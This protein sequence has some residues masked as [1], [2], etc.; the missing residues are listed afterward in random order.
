[1]SQQSIDDAPFKGSGLEDDLT[2]LK[3][4]VLDASKIALKHFGNSPDAQKKADGTEVSEADLEVNDHLFSTLTGARPDYGWLSEES[5]KTTDRFQ[6]ERVWIVDPIDG[7]RGFLQNKTD[8]TIAAGLLE[9]G[10]PVVGVV[11]APARDEF[12]AAALGTPATL[13]GAQI[14][15]QDAS[16]IEG[17]RILAGKSL[18]KSPH[19]ETPWPNIDLMWSN[20]MAYRICLVAKG[21]AHATISVNAK[22]DWDLAGA[23]TI[24]ASAGG[25]MTADSGATP[26]YNKKNVLHHRIIAAGPDLSSALL[27]RLRPH[28]QL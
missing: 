12:F 24:L 10:K 1:M 23:H 8:W 21:A 14:K 17:T 4:A 20:S 26:V 2:L 7:T 28:D 9:N 11:F 16:K 15:V 5:P 3:D 6:K 18:L 22:S 25:I 27:K 19:W 13:N